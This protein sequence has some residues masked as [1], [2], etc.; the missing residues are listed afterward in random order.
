MFTSF[1]GF[2]CLTCITLFVVFLI[3][4]DTHSKTPRSCGMIFFESC[5][6]GPNGTKE[7]KKVINDFDY[8]AP[9]GWHNNRHQNQYQQHHLNINRHNRLPPRKLLQYRQNPLEIFRSKNNIH[10]IKLYSTNENEIESVIGIINAYDQ[11]SILIFCNSNSM[12]RMVYEKIL[13]HFDTKQ[14]W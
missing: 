14:I 4:F 6:S 8:P 1:C 5:D 10:A 9:Q 11:D 2:L 13:N 7:I 3:L 12:V